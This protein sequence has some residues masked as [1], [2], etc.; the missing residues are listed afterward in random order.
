MIMKEPFPD[1]KFP[2]S[3]RA[4]RAATDTALVESWLSAFDPDDS[5]GTL[6]LYGRVQGRFFQWMRGRGLQLRTLK[7]EDLNSWKSGLRG[8]PST[9]ATAVSVVKSL[10]GYAHRSGYLPF[11]AA[12]ALRGPKVSPDPDARTLTESD[13]EAMISEARQALALEESREKPRPRTLKTARLRLRLVLWT[14]VT[15]CRISEVA[16]AHWED[17]HERVDGDFNLSVLGKGRKRRTISIP[18]RIIQE[19]AE[20][21]PSEHSGPVFEM[22][23]RRLQTLIKDLAVRAG[24]SPSVSAHWLRHGHASHSVDRGA[25]L[26]LVQRNLGHATLA[27]TGRYLHRTHVGAGKYLAIV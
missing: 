17:L 15:G 12:A 21:N 16:N 23:A 25:P 3:I 14:Y 22:G 26:H 5:A 2:A 20:G 13:V 9:R 8:A 4:T 11:N 27:T 6:V 7:V 19:I 10:L 1:Q 18:R 24:L